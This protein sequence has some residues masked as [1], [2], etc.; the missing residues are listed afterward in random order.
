MISG[1]LCCDRDNSRSS[2]GRSNNDGESAYVRPNSGLQSQLSHQYDTIWRDGQQRSEYFELHWN[3]GTQCA[4]LTITEICR[5]S[6]DITCGCPFAWICITAHF[7]AQ[8]H[9]VISWHFTLRWNLAHQPW[10][11]FT[12]ILVFYAF[13]RFR[14]RT[15][16]GTDG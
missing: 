7:N 1:L 15:W 2:Q 9:M 14:I 16:Y 4:S 11:T 6:A 3:C 10:E 5:Q 12:P 13:F 8:H